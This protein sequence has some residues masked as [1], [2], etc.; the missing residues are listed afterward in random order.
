MNLR[1]YEKLWTSNYGDLHKSFEMLSR[2]PSFSLV[3]E[4]KIIFCAGVG[5][6]WNGVGEAWM[7]MSETF[8]K[9][10]LTAFKLTKKYLE[11]I[12]TNNDFHRVQ[13]VCHEF[14]DAANRWAKHL[15]FER[16]GLLKQ[17][18]ADKSNFIRYAKVM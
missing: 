10:P 13:L 17:Y 1:E 9:Y 2:S 8:H 15:G 5:K 14:F 3:H 4:D 12:I 16:E 18:G 11:D 7:M 6:M